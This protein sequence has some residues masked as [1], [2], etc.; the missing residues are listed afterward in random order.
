MHHRRAA[1]QA[2]PS[3]PHPGHGRRQLSAQAILRSSPV[4]RRG[5]RGGAK[6]DPRL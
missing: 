1:R 2:D 4:S 5:C 6:P 3:R